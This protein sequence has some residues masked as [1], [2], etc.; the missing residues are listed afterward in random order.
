MSALKIVRSGCR[1]ESVGRDQDA[2]DALLLRLQAAGAKLESNDP[3]LLG[4]LVRYAEMLVAENE[5]PPPTLR[6]VKNRP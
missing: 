5:T 6:G 4:I 3:A 2:L 1:S